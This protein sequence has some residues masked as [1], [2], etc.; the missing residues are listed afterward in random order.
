MD[1]RFM[2]LPVSLKVAE[3]SG[4]G[5]LEDPS[6]KHF[7]VEDGDGII[8]LVTRRS[9]VIYPYKWAGGYTGG[10]GNKGLSGRIRKNHD[11]ATFLQ[12]IFLR[13][14]VCSGHVGRHDA[15]P[16]KMSVE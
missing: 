6:K 8:G 3:L 10:R 4:Q 13:N 12:N 7:L 16:P 2:V 1:T 5:Y 9:S 11:S 15:I 14:V